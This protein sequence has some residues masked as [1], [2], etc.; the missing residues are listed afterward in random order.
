MTQLSILLLIVAF[1]ISAGLFWLGAG[2]VAAGLRGASSAS[3]W[4]LG[5]VGTLLAACA[6]WW[7]GQAMPAQPVL[8]SGHDAWR[9]VAHLPGLL[10]CGAATAVAAWLRQRRHAE[11]AAG[12]VLLPVLAYAHAMLFAPGVLH[13]P[14]LRGPAGP[15][16]FLLALVL[17][18]VMLQ[19][20]WRRAGQ[21]LRL[22][23]AL[24]S[25]T[26]ACLAAVLSTPDAPAPSAAWQQVP[27]MA[28]LLALAA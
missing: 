28:T 1:V 27:A 8:G 14:V 10:L 12:A 2:L 13:A 20:G 21:G 17:A 9:F 19:A 15:G 11:A 26:L 16:L 7:P 22:G 4:L 18:L 5:A 3:R 23:A 24:A 25:A 6:L